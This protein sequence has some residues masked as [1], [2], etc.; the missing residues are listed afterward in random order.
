VNAFYALASAAWRYAEDR[1]GRLL[2]YLLMFLLANII[3]L[4]EPFVIGRLVNSIQQAATLENPLQQML[5][6]FFLMILIP[7]GFWMFHGPARVMENI[8]AFHA[9]TAFKDHLFQIVTAL[10]IQWHKDHHSGQTINKIGKA[11]HALYDF[12]SNGYN[13]IEMVIKLFGS[14]VVLFLILPTAAGIALG[15]SL[16]AFTIVFIIDTFLLASYDALNEKDHF[17]ASAL[18]DYVTNITTVITLRLER[19]TQSELWQRMTHYFPL[20]KSNVK[21]DEWKWFLTTIVI[22][23]MT[24]LVLAWYVWSTL[25]A[26]APLLVGTF[27]MLYDY[28]QKIGGAFYT[29]AWKYS[30]TIQQYADLRAAQSILRA[31]RAHAHTGLRLPAGWQTIEIKDL[32]FSYDEDGKRR[33]LDEVYLTLERG[34]KIALVGESGSGKSTLMSLIRGLHT[35]DR[36]TVLCDGKKLR[37]GLRTLSEHVTLIPQEPEIFANTIEYNITVDTKQSKKELM[38]DV[39]LA[40]FGPVLARLPHGLKTDIAEKGVNLS[41]GEKQ[42]LALARG[43]FAAKKSDII[44]LDEPTSSVDSQNEFAIHQ[45][46]FKR[47]ADRCIVSSIHRLHLLPLFDEIYVFERG[48]LLEHGTPQELLQRP[49]HLRE[50]W[51]AYLRSAEKEEE[52]LTATQLLP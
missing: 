12:M 35:T 19:L 1:R 31:E 4:V 20:Y 32:H 38:E 9:R 52:G 8:V 49:G 45:N 47:F 13:F 37:H 22:S 51:E 25:R 6:Y 11:T 26:G 46:I 39:E 17:V 41:G 15:V 27:Y 7:I 30:N 34:K 2:T 44:L 42:R 14:V 21:L 23:L 33:H 16:F 48:K 40:R 24:V 18:H 28:L 5:T 10:Q 29:F 36:A 43:I 3:L 50:L